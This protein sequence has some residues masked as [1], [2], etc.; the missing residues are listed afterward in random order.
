MPSGGGAACEDRAPAQCAAAG[1]VNV[2]SAG[3]DVAAGAP[4]E[5]AAIRA[6]IASPATAACAGSTG[7]QRPSTS[8][9]E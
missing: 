1:G 7:R 5:P 2:D 4:T 9:G 6:R 3:G 8:I